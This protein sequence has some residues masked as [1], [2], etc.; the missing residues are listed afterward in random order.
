ME[1]GLYILLFVLFVILLIVIMFSGDALRK[2]NTPTTT[3]RNQ[4]NVGTTVGTVGTTP[5]PVQS[6]WYGSSPS[7]LTNITNL[8]SNITSNLDNKSYTFWNV[9]GCGNYVSSK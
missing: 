2:N 9:D 1:N 3:M 5:K 8:T 6:N 4:Q 7:I